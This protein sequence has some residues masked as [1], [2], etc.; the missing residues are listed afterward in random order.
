READRQKDEFLAML[1]HE[2]RN[3]LAAIRNATQLLELIKADDPELARIQQVLERQTAHTA[4]LIDG[5]L[6]V[7]RIVRG[8]M[9]LE[10]QT[11]ELSELIRHVAEDRSASIERGRLTLVLELPR[12]PIWIAADR[13]RIVQVV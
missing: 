7:S 12:Q 3:P 11:L 13:V 2:L 6:D 8:K 4:R 10:R 1:G 9:R 5:L